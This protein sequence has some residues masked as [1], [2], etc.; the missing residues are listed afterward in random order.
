MS[1][2][3][4]AIAACPPRVQRIGLLAAALASQRQEF[5]LPR[6]H[7]EV[8][9]ILRRWQHAGLVRWTGEDYRRTAEWSVKR[10]FQLLAGRRKG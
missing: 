9:A 1:A 4:T 8:L 6:D 2:T 3:D 7:D 10:A 5:V